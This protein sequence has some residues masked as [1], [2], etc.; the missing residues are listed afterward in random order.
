VRLRVWDGG[1]GW[2]VWR[3]VEVEGM[4]W[5]QR[6]KVLEQWWMLRVHNTYEDEV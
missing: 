2:G 6:L 4:G 5:W 3:L 1:G